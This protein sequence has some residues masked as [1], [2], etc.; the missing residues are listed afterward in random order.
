MGL[1]DFIKGTNNIPNLTNEELDAKI[2]EKKDISYNKYL[3]CVPLPIIA[4]ANFP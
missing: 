3:Y 1:F 2:L 4:G